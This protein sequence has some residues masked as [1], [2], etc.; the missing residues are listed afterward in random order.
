MRGSIEAVGNQL[1]TC[2]TRPRLHQRAK[3]HGHHGDD[4]QQLQHGLRR[5]RRRRSTVNSST[6]TLTLPAGATVTW[7]GLYWGADTSAGTG[8][9]AAPNAANRGTVRF[10][11]G[12]GAY[13]TVTANAA[14]VLTSTGAA[15]RYRAF[16]NVTSRVPATAPTRSATCRPAA[17][18]TATPA[19]RWSSPTRTRPRT[20][21]GSASTTASAR[22]TPRTP[23]RPTSRRSTRPR[24]GPVATKTGLLAFEGDAGLQ[25]EVATFNGNTLTDPL[26]TLNNLMNSSMTVDGVYMGGRTPAYNNTQGTD[27]D[28]FNSTGLLANHQSSA[29]LAF[30]STQDLFVP[31]ALWLV[32]D[33][34]P[35]ANTTGP[36]IGGIA[37]D[38]STLTA[39]PG[40]GTARRRSPTST[41]GSAATPPAT[42]A[43][44]SPARPAARTR[45]ARTTSAARSASSSPPSTTP[46]PRTRRPRARPARSGSSRPP[47][48]RPGRQRHPAGRRD[49]DHDARRLDR[50]RAAGL[51]RPVAA[52]R[53]RRRQLHRHRRRHR[54][55]LRAHRRRRRLDDPQRGH[56]LQRRRL[57]HRRSVTGGQVDPVAPANTVVPAGH[58]R[59]ARRPDADRRRRHLDRHRPIDYDYQWQRC[60]ARRHRLRAIAGETGTTYVLTGDDIGHAVRVEV[61]A[62]NVAGNAT[63]NSAR[64]P[65]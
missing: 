20:C 61:T 27:I 41:S 56:R 33:E 64:P 16:A 21:T 50:H 8:G 5:H 11:A 14:D 15:T 34:G 62:T 7:A 60:D 22:S 48:S 39:D 53:H 55:E 47:T 3:P 54:L 58:R 59:R 38:G 51:R 2:P 65:R 9:S 26:N 31:S 40:S 37:R 23:S 10:K 25:T 45:S 6:A 13:Q 42:T 44:T 18:T 12:A 1:L 52:L 36:T 29:I 30:S 63:A 46:A 57:R 35:A 43:S 49:A 17:A 32:S 4:E 28:V 19:G 24:A